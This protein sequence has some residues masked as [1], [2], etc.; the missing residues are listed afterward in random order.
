[1]VT[2]ITGCSGFIG[3]HLTK[4]ILIKNKFSKVIGIDNMNTYYD[5]KLKEERKKNLLRLKNKN[6]VFFKIDISNKKKL[7]LIFKKYK[8]SR[9]FHFAAQAGVR[10]SL[11]NPEQY[12][13]SNIIGFFNLL[14]CAKEF[15]VKKFFFASSSSVY[16][17]VKSKSYFHEEINTNQPVSFY[18]ATKKSN[19]VMAHSYSKIYNLKLVGLRFF[20]VYGPFGRPDM[21]YYKFTKK[22]LNNQKID[23]YNNGNHIRDFTYI[24]DV[25]NSILLLDKNFK[26]I[27]S[28]FEIFNIGASMP[29]SLKN[30]IKIIESHLDK[31]AKINKIKFQKGDVIGTRASILKLKRITNYN[32]KI[33]LS[34][35]IK[36]FIIWYKSFEK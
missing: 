17:N 33:N 25:V 12:L 21:A 8:I 16:G 15:N 20:T 1:M 7:D 36:R 11:N 26:K 28:K 31:K 9:I 23:M 4:S 24:D 18:A 34:E 14:E 2:L 32:P 19:E 5:I 29:V 6:F 27:N 30:F 22:I 13:N 10:Y 3:F 35:G